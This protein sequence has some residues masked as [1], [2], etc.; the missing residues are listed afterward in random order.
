MKC[1]LL[2]AIALARRNESAGRWDSMVSLPLVTSRRSVSTARFEHPKYSGR[3]RHSYNTLPT[4]D[5]NYMGGRLAQLREIGPIN[6]KVRSRLFKRTPELSQYSVDI[7]CAQQTLRKRWK[8]RD[9]DVVEL[10]FCAAPKVL[11][12][13]IP[14]LYTDVPQMADPANGDRRNLHHR[15][16]D[17]EELQHIIMSESR[18]DAAPATLVSRLQVVKRDSMT[19]DK[20][21]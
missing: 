4:H 16:F 19:L 21:L 20:F 2:S 7:W 6:A 13:V 3:Q 11:Q 12:R 17:A 8:A 5:A 14:E 9:W 15:V 10:P 1:S 18:M